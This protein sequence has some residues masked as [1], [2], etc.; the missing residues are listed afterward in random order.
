MNLFKRLMGKIDALNPWKKDHQQ[1]QEA[2]KLEVIQKGEEPTK[3]KRNRPWNN[4]IPR[5]W[6]VSHRYH[7]YRSSCWRVFAPG[8]EAHIPKLGTPGRRRAGRKL[9]RINR[10]ILRHNEIMA[11]VKKELPSP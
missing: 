10:R 1:D 7:R 5:A 9:E 8:I 11:R 2:P 4:W 3:P 6:N